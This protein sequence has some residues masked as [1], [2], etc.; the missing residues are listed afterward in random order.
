MVF[1]EVLSVAYDADTVVSLK[2]SKFRSE[3]S[4]YREIPY[5]E[6]SKNRDDLLRFYLNGFNA[7]GFTAKINKTDIFDDCIIMGFTLKNAS[8][9]YKCL[10]IYWI[11][12]HVIYSLGFFSSERTMLKAFEILSSLRIDGLLYKDWMSGC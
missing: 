11:R 5:S 9:V 3:Y 10:E 6:K 7:R 1:V 4:S 12:N 2:Q 8:D